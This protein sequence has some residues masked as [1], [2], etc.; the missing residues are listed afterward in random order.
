MTIQLNDY[1]QSL[2]DAEPPKKK[3]IWV[4]RL[5]YC[6]FSWL[7]ILGLCLEY[8]GHLNETAAN[9]LHFGLG[10]AV[11]L[12]T[13]GVVSLVVIRSV[14]FGFKFAMNMSDDPSFPSREE[15]RNSL[16]S[17]IKSLASTGIGSWMKL[18]P[19]RI[20]D[21]LTDLIMFVM[22][23]SSNYLIL[24][25]AFFVAVMLQWAIV[26]S[27]TRQLAWLLSKVPDPLQATKKVD[28]DELVD[29]LIYGKP[30]SEQEP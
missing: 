21:N 12:A 13:I 9:W 20:F 19:Y 29:D 25:T 1:Q 8:S 17:A 22:L 27:N 14:L 7:L 3:K 15:R 2:L 18:T 4:R 11:I 16:Y 28:L 5:F 6:T 24:G 26:R 30:K 23:I 10:A